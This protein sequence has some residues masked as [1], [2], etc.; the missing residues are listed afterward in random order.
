LQQ[1][2]VILKVEDNSF[3]YETYKAIFVLHVLKAL[4]LTV[5][6]DFRIGSKS[7]SYVRELPTTPAL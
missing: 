4:A 3:V 5:I 7:Q 1:V 6:S 2:A